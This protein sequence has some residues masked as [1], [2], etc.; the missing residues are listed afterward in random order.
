[1]SVTV[2]T[3]VPWTCTVTPI[4]DSPEVSVMLPLTVM[5]WAMLLKEN[6]AK[7][8]SKI[9]FFRFRFFCFISFFHLFRL[10]MFSSYC[11]LLIIEGYYLLV[12]CIH[13]YWGEWCQ[14][15]NQCTIWLLENGD[16]FSMLMTFL[17]GYEMIEMHKCSLLCHEIP[18][19][20]RFKHCMW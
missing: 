8:I 2:P 6:I 11:F 4:R 17:I 9:P 13:I 5:F 10:V 3:D 19:A 15:I 14:S 16:L 1:M 18:H 7:Q 20:M 12:D